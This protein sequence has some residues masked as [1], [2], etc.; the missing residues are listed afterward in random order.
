MCRGL[1]VWWV[2]KPSRLLRGE[3]G[4][5]RYAL[6][7]AHCTLH[8]THYTPPLT[9][10]LQHLQHSIVVMPAQHSPPAPL[11]LLL[12]HELAG[13]NVHPG[14]LPASAAN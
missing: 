6:Y 3:L 12:A 9:S 14:S 10:T 5:V 1:V 13:F 11:L 4:K 7:T 2:K 8:T